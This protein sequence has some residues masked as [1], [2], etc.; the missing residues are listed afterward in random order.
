MSIAE[1][2]YDLIEI[3]ATFV[4]EFQCFIWKKILLCDFFLTLLK[5]PFLYHCVFDFWDLCWVY[6]VKE[7]AGET[8]FQV[9]MWLWV[10]QHFF[11]LPSSHPKS[12]RHSAQGPGAS[13]IGAGFYPGYC[14]Q[15]GPVVLRHR[16]ADAQWHGSSGWGCNQ[17]TASVSQAETQVACEE[18]HHHHFRHFQS[19]RLF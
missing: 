1:C 2:F 16:A 13:G 5:F 11:T 17:T 3:K 12:S 18:E 8:V 9:L 4:F 7:V 14:S 6:K 19:M 15:Q 10:P